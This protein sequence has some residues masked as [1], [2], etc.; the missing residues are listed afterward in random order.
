MKHILF[1][2]DSNTWGFVTGSDFE[3]YPYEKRIC[4]LMQKGLGDDYRVIEE[5]LNGRTTAFDDPMNDDKNGLKQLPLILDKNRPLD[6]VIMMLGTN[7]MKH[8]M[9][10]TPTDSALGINKLIDVIKLS[11]C[12]VKR[13]CPKILL[14]SPVHYVVPIQSFGRLFEGAVEKSKGYLAAYREI[15][16][17]RKVF[18]FDAASVASPPVSGD[19]IHLNDTGAQLIGEALIDQVR[20]II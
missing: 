7:D 12:G 4:G 6:L 11:G 5:A 20:N 16:E 3:R 19:G 13:Q 2:G 18:F 10:L 9:H 8:Y 1:Y 14:V 15:S 17:Q